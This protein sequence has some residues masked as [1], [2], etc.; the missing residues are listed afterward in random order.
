MVVKAMFVGVYAMERG[1]Q[2][3]LGWK[4]RLNE[5]L[6]PLFRAVALET[7]VGQYHHPGEGK[8]NLCVARRV[9]QRGEVEREPSW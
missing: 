5:C 2:S 1:A 8:E 7:V 9:L 3:L 4:V 6:A